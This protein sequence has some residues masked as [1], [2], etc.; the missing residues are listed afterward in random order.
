MKKRNLKNKAKLVYN[1][2][3]GWQ[4]RRHRWRFL[5]SH[6]EQNFYIQS[7]VDTHGFILLLSLSALSKEK[8]P[9]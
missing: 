4:Y 2:Q 3:W 1:F 7:R 8:S 9:F 6:P 5:Y